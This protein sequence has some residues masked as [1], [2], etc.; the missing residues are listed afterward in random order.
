MFIDSRINYL[1]R[2]D[3]KL[4]LE[5]EDVLAIELPTDE[6]HAKN[7]IIIIYIYRPPSIQ[8]NL[9]TEKF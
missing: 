2:D 8:V 4:D 1:S 7:N 6:L 9:F 3:S 5:F